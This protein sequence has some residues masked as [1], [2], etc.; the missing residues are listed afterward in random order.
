MQSFFL[1]ERETEICCRRHSFKLLSVCLSILIKSIF[2]S[3]F[4]FV[5]LFSSK[6]SFVLFFCLSFYFHQKHLS[7]FFSLSFYYNQKHLSYSFSVCLSILVCF[8]FFCFYFYSRLFLFLLFLFLFS[9]VS[10]SSVCI[11]IL[12][13]ISFCLFYC[14]SS[15]RRNPSFILFFYF[16]IC[17]QKNLLSSSFLFFIFATFLLFYFATLT[18]SRGLVSYPGGAAD[19]FVSTTKKNIFISLFFFHYFLFFIYY[20]VLRLPFRST[21]GRDWK[22]YFLLIEIFFAQTTFGQHLFIFL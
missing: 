6:A 1:K 17:F 7:R 22:I 11:S 21:E 15:S 5:F 14:F 18:F 13:K 10:V 4:L 16:S 20:L 19:Q 2:R 3:L 8:C 12:K 9:S